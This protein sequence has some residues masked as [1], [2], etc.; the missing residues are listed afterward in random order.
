MEKMIQVGNIRRIHLG[1][2]LHG[3]RAFDWVGGSE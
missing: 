1:G 2:S 3:Q